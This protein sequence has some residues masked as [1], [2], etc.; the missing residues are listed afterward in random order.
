MK[1]LSPFYLFFCSIC[2]VFN[3]HAHTPNDKYMEDVCEEEINEP[4]TPDN[5]V[6]DTLTPC[7]EQ[8]TG[9]VI[10]MTNSDRDANVILD[11][12]PTT[13]WSD[14]GNLIFMVIDLQEQ[15]NV[16][17][18]RISFPGERRY[19]FSIRISEHSDYGWT[20]LITGATSAGYTRS[21]IFETFPAIEPRVGRYISISLFGNNFN[22]MNRINEIEFI[23]DYTGDTDARPGISHQ[24]VFANNVS[25]L[26][27]RSN[28]RRLALLGMLDEDDGANDG[29][30]DSDTG[31]VIGVDGHARSSEYTLTNPNRTSFSPQYAEVLADLNSNVF[32]YQESRDVGYAPGGGGGGDTGGGG[33][34]GGVGDGGTV[35]DSPTEATGNGDNIAGMQ[36]KL[37]LPF[38]NDDDGSADEID[39]VT[40]AGGYN[41]EHYFGSLD[42]GT[43][44]ICP[45]K[46][47]RTSS[48]TKYS[49]CELREMLRAGNDDHSTTGISE[50]NW[51]LRNSPDLGNGCSNYN[52]RLAATLAVNH[53]TTTGEEYQIGRVIIGQIHGAD[54][55]PI[56]LYYRKL[57]GNANGSIYYASEEFGGADIWYEMIGSLESDASNPTDGIPLNQTFSYEIVVVNEVMTVT[58]N[59][60]SNIFTRSNSLSSYL[61]NGEYLYFKAGVYN[62]NNSGLPN[63]YV[64]ATFYDIE[65]TH[66]RI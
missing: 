56:R 33:T 13:T 2:F 1:H 23:G 50:N 26:T 32:P 20:N 19:N 9:P 62:Q 3:L 15:V 51:L 55:E 45:V 31:I 5:C 66:D 41:D 16:S 53:V 49:R 12:D 36:W 37:T 47:D 14:V 22:S 40:L 27:T 21:N 42:G 30:D 43:T 39:E 52:G 24:N 65:N 63:D 11:G 18:V 6:I 44:F 64:Q 38:D 28:R 48:A 59:T 34:G 54:D 25:S 46:G 35:V 7:E 29:D 10:L 8:D 61:E 60:G 4:F 17:A 58:I 57:P